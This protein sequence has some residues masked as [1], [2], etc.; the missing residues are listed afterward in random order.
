MIQEI[1]IKKVASFDDE[2]I[3]FS[4]TLIN[5]LYGSNGSGKTTI[6]NAIRDCSQYPSCNLDWGLT[7]PLQTLVYNR[8][9]VEENFGN[10]IKGIFTLGKD[11]KEEN[12]K[13][14]HNKSQIEEK[15]KL[16][17][18][19]KGTLEIKKSEIQGLQSKFRNKCWSAFNKY[20]P[21]FQAAF[22]GHRN[23]AESFKDRIILEFDT[24][25]QPVVNLTD[26]E[27]KAQTIFNSD[28]SKYPVIADFDEFDFQTLENDP[29][30]QTRI[31]GKE[32]IDI[33][34]MIQKLNNSD[35]V[36]QG[37]S[38]YEGNEGYCPF[39]QQTTSEEFSQQLGDFFD[40][41]YDQQ[42]QT[43]ENSKN[44]YISTYENLMSAV[45]EYLELENSYVDSDGLVTLKT[46]ITSV[47]EKNLLALDRK[48]KEPTVKIE[49]TSIVEYIEKIKSILTKARTDTQNHN[50]LLENIAVERT[51]LTSKIWAFV[52]NELKTDY[53]DFT[54]EK[55]NVEKAFKAINDRIKEN[56]EDIR[57][58]REAIS[59]SQDKITSI[60]PTVDAINKTLSGFGF[61]NFL[62]A[63]GSELGSYKIIRQDGSDAK[64]TLSEGE[65]TF[66]T[67]LY[68]YHLTKGSI[69]TENIT[70][71]KVL[72]IDDPISSLDSS[73][74][75]VVSSLVRELISDCRKNIGNIK[76][77][78][79]LTHNVYFHK[80]ITFK[81]RSESNRG[82]SFWTLKKTETKS[83]IRKHQVN[84]IQTSYE[85]LW[86]ELTDKENLNKV[87]IFNTL[88]RILEYYFKILGKR[89]EDTLLR[90]FEGEEKIIGNA[91]LTWINDGSHIVN[92]DLFIATDEE[93]LEKYLR[94]F[95]KIF[96][97]E[98]HLAHYN[99]MMGNNE[100][101][102]SD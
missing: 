1:S 100:D 76:Q 90:K 55:S 19:L 22:K 102:I 74:L 58:F 2:G 12:E 79:V 80:E 20:D 73:V 3:I 57:S 53:D 88:R 92:D 14:R 93:D 43:L 48:E 37:I 21:K 18:T 81:K 62:L 89:K 96:E 13:I 11:S 101:S 28:T 82:E 7:I 56:N 27:A 59:E 42:I 26:L 36:R 30:F 69:Q 6:S 68:F 94:V 34:K 33:S 54:K 39:C 91:L 87:T 51:D 8:D 24:N 25:G 86:Q 99:M 97:V 77:V 29:I 47:Y 49:L 17:T 44:A 32:D 16:I 67:F 85:L 98:N 75:F 65:K 66:I 72:V 4:P 70:A 23:S 40:E 9:F 60:K 84:P 50:Q 31:V 5:F 78:F 38:F 95:K 46:L 61:T 71:N 52:I 10:E 35:W 15:E 64:T 83:V 63:E 41:N 45:S